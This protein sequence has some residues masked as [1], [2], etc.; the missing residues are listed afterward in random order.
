MKD[1]LKIETSTGFDQGGSTCMFAKGQG[2]GGI[3]SNPG[4]G[5]RLIY[6]SLLLVSTSEVASESEVVEIA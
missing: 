2:D 6:S 4:S 5:L 1:F 3:V